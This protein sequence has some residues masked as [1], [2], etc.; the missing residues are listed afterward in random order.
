M[1][2]KKQSR[3]RWAVLLR[4]R[5]VRLANGRPGGGWTDEF[6]VICRDCGDNP[7]LDYREVSP[8]L[9]R[10]RGP[11]RIEAGVAACERHARLPPTPYGQDGPAGPAPRPG[12]CR[13]R[14]S[15]R[16]RQRCIT[17]PLSS[18]Q[19][20]RY[21]FFDFLFFF[22]SFLLFLATRITPLPSVY[23]STKR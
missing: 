5:P 11:Y 2:T 14:V 1:K 10:I 3:R 6:E 4:R 12:F 23:R 7:D 19:G 8:E 18:G 16:G 13:A 9:Q 17:G 15:V 21:F 20:N 22:L